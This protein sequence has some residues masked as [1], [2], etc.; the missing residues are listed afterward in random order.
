MSG[1]ETGLGRV[2]S[3][4]FG[5][6]RRRTTAGSGFTLLEVVVVLAMIGLM[7]ALVL[8]RIGHLSSGLVLKNTVSRLESGFAA[9]ALRARATGRVVRLRLD[10]ARHALV[11]E[12]SGGTGA[13]AASGGGS[14]APGAPG[15]GPAA[16]QPDLDRLQAIALPKDVKWELAGEAG[17][18]GPAGEDRGGE[19]VFFPSGEASGPEILITVGKHRVRLGLD[20]LTGRLAE[21]HDGG[22]G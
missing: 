19:F 20:R 8:P 14:E 4:G 10:S 21:R 12:E 3:P 16:P 18:R 11:A 13:A 9:A 17:D 22:A 6:C 15:E 7:T 5:D 1:G 2:L